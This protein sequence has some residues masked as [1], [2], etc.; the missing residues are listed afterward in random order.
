MDTTNMSV[1]E[2]QSEVDSYASTIAT[3]IGEDPVELKVRLGFDDIDTKPLIENI[4]KKLKGT[5]F[6]DKVGELSLGDLKIAADLEVGDDTIQSWDELKQKIEEVKNAI[7]DETSLSF[8]D[9]ISQIQS[10][11]KGLDQLDKIYAEPCDFSRGRF[12]GLLS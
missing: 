10:L 11:S 1:G 4:K 12:S 5:E 8:T 3:A 6:D 7:S 2:I 9:T